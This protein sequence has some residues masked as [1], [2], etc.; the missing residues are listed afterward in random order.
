MGRCPTNYLMP[1]M[2]ISEQFSSF[3]TRP[4]DLVSYGVLV[5]VSTGYPP[6][7]GRLHTRYAPIRRSPPVCCHTALPLDLHVLG[8]PLAFILSQDQTLHC[9]NC[10]FA[11]LTHQCLQTATSVAASDTRY[12]LSQNFNVLSLL[13]GFPLSKASAKIRPFSVLANLFFSLT[14]FFSVIR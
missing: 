7:G 13:Q 11:F 6:L 1:R 12:L 10:F 14:T 8:L 9:K 4:C 5:R 2:P 3:I